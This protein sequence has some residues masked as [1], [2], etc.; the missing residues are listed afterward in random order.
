MLTAVAE[1]ARTL[2]IPD[3]AD[4]FDADANR[5]Q[6]YL[7]ENPDVMRRRSKDALD[8]PMGVAEGVAESA[9]SILPTV[10]GAA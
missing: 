2:G 1:G 10:L 7:N 3:V 4:I 9:P 6:R 5:V 8:G